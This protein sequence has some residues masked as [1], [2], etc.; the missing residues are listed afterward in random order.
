[1]NVAAQPIGVAPASVD[2][3]HPAQRLA[4]IG[5]SEILAI[6]AQAAALKQQGRP[7]IIL[8]TG[9]PDFDTP[10]HIKEA[11]ARAMR[12]GATKYTTLDGTAA[13]KSAVR[14]KFKRENDLD[15]ALDE[16]TVGARAKQVIYNAMMATLNPGDEVI[17]PAPY[18]V[19]YADI[20]LIC[21]GVPVIVP[22]AEQNGFRLKPEHLERA[23][24]PRTR[25]LMINSPSNPSGAAY[26]EAD[27]R[28]ILDLVM[29]HPQMWLMVDDIYEHIVYDGFK[30]T[31]PAAIAPELK[32]R[33]LT[34]NGV[35]KAYA[36]TGWRL[37]YGAGP[38]PL[39]KAMA[40]AQSQSTSCPSS[41]S[42]AAGIAA[43]LG[44]Q[45]IVR[46]RCAEFQRRRDIVVTGLNAIAGLNCFKPQGAFYTFASCAGV[47][48]KR[49]A[50]GKKLTT[51]SDF[52][53]YLLSAQDVAI[54][55]G[56]AFGL[57]PYFRISYATSVAELQ[58]ALRRIAIA[59]ADLA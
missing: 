2:P 53:A 32:A 50:D 42:Q 39:I 8:G 7:V 37:G 52:C 24:T 31:T 40:V 34:I 54:V 51:G 47:L 1:M 36:M 18:W 35:S 16:I 14:E 55:P 28:P 25:W 57:G 49:T 15:V 9:E 27:Y 38:K 6:T 17:I 3:F 29:R 19:T 5:V 23:I 22:C 11:A 58:E 20:V 30:F 26:A 43:L 33:T 48:G 44:P 21:G 45:D 41:I 10:D 56:S 12:E 59:C 4:A 46:E 13:M